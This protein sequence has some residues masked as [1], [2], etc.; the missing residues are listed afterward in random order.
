MRRGPLVALTGYTHLSG[1]WMTIH[2]CEGQRHTQ[3]LPSLSQYDRQPMTNRVR[4]EWV[5]YAVSKRT[6]LRA[7]Y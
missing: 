4:K 5:Q 7:D 6:D 1:N 2:Q 3:R